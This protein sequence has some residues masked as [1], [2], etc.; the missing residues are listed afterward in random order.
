MYLA[1]AFS[2]GWRDCLATGQISSDLMVMKNTYTI[3]FS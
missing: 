2:A 1:M 3:E